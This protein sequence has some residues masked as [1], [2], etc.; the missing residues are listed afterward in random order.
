MDEKIKLILLNNLYIL[1]GILILIILL[2]FEIIHK[3]F[4]YNYLINTN[5]IIFS[6]IYLVILF[7]IRSFYLSKSKLNIRK[8]QNLFYFVLLYFILFYFILLFLRGFKIIDLMLYLI[9]NLIITFYIY[10]NN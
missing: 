9:I 4:G 7:L 8:I 10:Y 6:F 3:I 5:V 2:L 1:I